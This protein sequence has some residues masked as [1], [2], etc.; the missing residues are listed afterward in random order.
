MPA[1]PTIYTYDND[2]LLT[3]AGAFTIARNSR[4][5][6]PEALTDG[7]LNLSCNFNG[8]GE[9]ND[10]RFSISGTTLTS[11]NLTRDNAGRITAKTETVEGGYVRLCLHL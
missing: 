7:S 1:R 11:C 4:N 8:Y 3:G 6:L 5:G 2:G 9:I 10:Q